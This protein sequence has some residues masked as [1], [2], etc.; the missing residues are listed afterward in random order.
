MQTPSHFLVTAVL[1]RNLARCGI[2]VHN[3]A[4]L[5]GSVLPDIPFILLTIGGEGYYRWFA[6]LPGEGSIMEYLHLT[7]FFTDPVWIVSHNFF[8]S[9]IL[10]P[11]LILVGF[12]GW[13]AHKQWAPPVIWLAASMGFHAVIDIFTHHSDGPLF[14][15]PLNWSYRFASPLSYWE[16]DYFG[17]TFMIFEYT[18]DVLILAYFG[19]V[20]WRRT[21]QSPRAVNQYE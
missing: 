16:A 2:P 9:L 7:L 10:N 11:V 12:L 15:F 5:V 14:L 21:R 20:W 6:V 18:L 4:F 19:F 1:S 8:H 3:M 17:G 13:H